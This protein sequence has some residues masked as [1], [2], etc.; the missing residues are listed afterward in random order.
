MPPK[1]SIVIITNEI[2][3]T[4][5]NKLE[6]I[7]RFNDG[8]CNK[9]TIWAILNKASEYQHQG[10][11]VSRSVSK[12]CSRNKTGVIIEMEDLL[13]FGLKIV[14]RSV[15]LSAPILSTVLSSL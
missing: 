12:Q 3:F 15:F 1:Q 5:D 11:L 10:T 13:F 6:V 9:L 7:K 4:L 2:F 14:I 8:E